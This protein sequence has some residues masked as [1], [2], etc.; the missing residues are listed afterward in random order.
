[1]GTRQLVLVALDSE[2]QLDSLEGQSQAGVRQSDPTGLFVILDES[3]GSAALAVR[4]VWYKDG[5]MIAGVNEVWPEGD[6]IDL[7]PSK[8][9]ILP[10]L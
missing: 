9:G 3:Q 1:V 6:S 4:G 10:V 8:Y 5:I 2:A 7:E